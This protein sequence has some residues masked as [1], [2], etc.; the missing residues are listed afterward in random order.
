MKTLITQSGSG[1]PPL[2]V[3]YRGGTP[4]PL[5]IKSAFSLQPSAF[6]L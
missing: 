2:L 1:V 4:L 3:Q 6:A 5:S